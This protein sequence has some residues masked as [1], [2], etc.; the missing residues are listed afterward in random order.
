MGEC[1]YLQHGRLGQSL[2]NALNW[3]HQWYQP[4]MTR[5][6]ATSPTPP[7]VESMERQP[8]GGDGLVF[9]FGVGLFYFFSLFP[10]LFKYPQYTGSG[11]R[12]LGCD[13]KAADCRFYQYFT[14]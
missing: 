8:S 4:L 5:A 12:E 1:R 7:L 6:M 11:L 3:I 2:A 10:F 14:I 9:P 13:L